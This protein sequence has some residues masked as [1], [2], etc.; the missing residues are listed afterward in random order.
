MAL[1]VVWSFSSFCQAPAAP[2]SCAGLCVC[3][4]ADSVTAPTTIAASVLLSIP[5]APP[6]RFIVEANAI[7]VKHGLVRYL[8]ATSS[9][10]L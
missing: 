5:H 2:S 3:A 4:T 7:G 10:V 8:A 1:A 9:S 6:S